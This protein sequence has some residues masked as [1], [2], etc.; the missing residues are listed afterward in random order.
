MPTT[1]CPMCYSSLDPAHSGAIAATLRK[2]DAVML[3]KAA[4]DVLADDLYAT[5]IRQLC[6]QLAGG[7]RLGGPSGSPF[8]LANELAHARLE[9]KFNAWDT[10]AAKRRAARIFVLLRDIARRYAF[11][12][13]DDIGNRLDELIAKVRRAHEFGVCGGH[14]TQDAAKDLAYYAGDDWPGIE[15]IERVLSLAREVFVEA[16]NQDTY[17]TEH[18]GRDRSAR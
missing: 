8:D 4:G 3:E 9:L 12:A 11:L 5:S 1:E 18:L 6:C 14:K 13:K 7:D 17:T 16:E 15:E 2:N 10:P